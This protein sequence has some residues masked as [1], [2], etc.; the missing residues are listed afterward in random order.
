MFS[1]LALSAGLS[2][3]L[4]LSGSLIAQTINDPI[5]HHP[6]GQTD[7]DQDT[8][9]TTGQGHFGQPGAAHAQDHP[10]VNG[11]CQLPGGTTEVPEPITV[12]LFGAGLAGVGY[13]ARRRRKAK[14]NRTT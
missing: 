9:L 10:P 2:L 3:I 4:G 13:A 8:L 14:A 12:I 7:H 6:P 5:C 11:S 1:K